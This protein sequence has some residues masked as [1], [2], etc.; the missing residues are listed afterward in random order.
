VQPVLAEP[1]VAP[2][3][4]RDA[5]QSSRH[6]GDSLNGG[7]PPSQG[8]QTDALARS[9]DHCGAGMSP[10]QDWCL[11]CGTAAPG[12]LGVRPGTRAMLTVVGITLLLAVGA[13]AASYAA[14][15]EDSKLD[16]ARPGSTD[17]AP[18]AQVPPTLPPASTPPG[19]ATPT[20][21]AAPVTPPAELPKITPPASVTPPTSTPITPPATSVTPTPTPTPSPTGTGNDEDLTTPADDDTKSTTPTATGITLG[22][23][24]VTIYDPYGRVTVKGDPADAYDDDRD[25]TFRIGTADPTKPMGVGLIIDLEKITPVRAVELLTDTPGYRVE[26]YGTSSSELPPDILDARWNHFS[27]RT[28]VDGSKKDGNVP[29]DDRERISLRAE[30]KVR[31]LNLWLTTPPEKGPIVRIAELNLFG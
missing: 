27:D 12:R 11:E 1:E 29:G 13:V 6:G 20:M 16:A 28:N 10:E 4:A 19:A 26:V 3:P 23:D 31:Y 25:S 24:A 21:P 18:V 8:A 15:S 9:C 17:S 14:L 5:D 2:R 30:R 22:A 7:S